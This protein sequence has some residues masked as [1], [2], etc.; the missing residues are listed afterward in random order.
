MSLTRLES[1]ALLIIFVFPPIFL[2]TAEK[3]IVNY[4]GYRELSAVSYGAKGIRNECSP[5]KHHVSFITSES[6]DRIFYFVEVLNLSEATYY[7]LVK[8]CPSILKQSLSEQIVPYIQHL[9]NELS[10]TLPNIA[11]IAKSFPALLSPWV[12]ANANDVLKFLKDLG[13]RKNGLFKVIRERPQ[14]LSLRV[15]RLC[16]KV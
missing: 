15:E 4:P 1:H 8:K 10:L 16:P 14:L 2:V 3:V 7:R 12:Q 9:S 13:L 5:S 6:Q 11:K